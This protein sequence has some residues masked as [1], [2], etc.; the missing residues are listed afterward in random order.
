MPLLDR[1]DFIAGTVAS[2]VALA[3][4]R[5]ARASEA[6]RTVVLALM[7]ANDRGSQL[8]ERFANR[9]D[10]RIAYVCDPDERAIAKGINAV[11]SQGGAA[12]QGVKDFRRALEDSAVDGIICAAPNHWHAAATVAACNAGKHVYV[13]KPCSH[14]PEEGDMMIAA[15]AKS[16]KVVQ[17]GMQRRSGPLYREAV[18]R[19]RAGAIGDV[20]L[21]KAWYFRDRPPL[22]HSAES[23]PPAWL[24]YSLWQGPAPERPYRDNTLHYN[25]HFF[26]HWGNAELGNNG[27]HTLDLCR[28]A[29]GVDYPSRVSVSGTRARYDDDQQTP[30]TT[31]ACFDCNGKMIVW[32]AVSW[33]APYNAAGG[34]G[35]EFRGGE[36]T[37]FIDD[38]AYTI[39]DRKGKQVE[40]KEASRGDDEHVTNFLDAI[41]EGVP[42]NANLE[43]GHKSAMFCHLGNISYRCGQTLE[44][45]SASGEVKNC[46]TA[47]NYWG[48]EYRPGWSPQ[49]LS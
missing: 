46:P 32:E 39:Y 23:A 7:G 21:G 30:D 37:M 43:E 48:R 20:L 12:P 5:V 2:G 42:L 28:W 1:R 27:V 18:E 3:T 11:T 24:D 22:G 25:W 38:R 40:R 47:A 49:E 45:D 19:L 17:V 14:T 6:N 36:G 10:V 9:S 34:V 29:L 31:I 35:L 33:A 4:R 16:G 15:A 41:R 44:V 8:M 13:E 26:W